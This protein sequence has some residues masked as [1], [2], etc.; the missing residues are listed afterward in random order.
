MRERLIGLVATRPGAGNSANVVREVMG[1]ANFWPSEGGTA[2]EPNKR[3]L[4]GELDVRKALRPTFTFPTFTL[5]VSDDTRCH[6]ER[7]LLTVKGTVLSA[8]I[9]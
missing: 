2:E 6:K 9:V 3:T 1:T 7:R 5:R 8:T 4:Q